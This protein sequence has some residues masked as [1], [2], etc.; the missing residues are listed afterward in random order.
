MFTGIVEEVGLVQ[1]KKKIGDGIEFI[2]RAKKV[3]K[4]LH[5]DNSICVN[6]VCLTIVKKINHEFTVQ[7]VKETLDKT[8]LGFLK[9][10]SAVNLERSVRLND[11][12]GGHL[13]QGH[14]DITG[15]VVGITTLKSSWMYTISFPKKF[16]K[17]LIPVGS[18]TVDGT[19]LTVARLN[20]QEL[21]IAIIPYT[22]EH[23]I[24]NQYKKGTMVNLEFDIIG[25]YIESI[26]KYK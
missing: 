8:N 4:V 14:V 21:T 17:N 23:T 25:K 9:T 6:G 2:I 16:R 26:V 15:T 5:V 18:I 1:S 19:S 12:L 7:A 20:R 3:S 11:R 24:F 13:V 10:G 22:F